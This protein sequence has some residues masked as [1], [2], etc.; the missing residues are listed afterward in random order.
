MQP[1]AKLAGGLRLLA[2]VAVRTHRQADD[3]RADLFVFDYF[4][5]DI[6]A[7]CFESRRV[8]VVSGEAMRRSVSLI[9]EAEPHGAGVDRRAGGCAASQVFLQAARFELLDDLF[10]V[11]FVVAMGDRI[12]SPS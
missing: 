5:S 2:F 11:A 3:D 7:S 1:G 9:G 4:L 12:A 10:D 8:Y 6:A